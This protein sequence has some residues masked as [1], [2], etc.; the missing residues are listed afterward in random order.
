MDVETN[1]SIGSGPVVD[2]NCTLL[3][4]ARWRHRNFWA[5]SGL[6]PG[7]NRFAAPLLGRSTRKQGPWAAILLA[8]LVRVV[9]VVGTDKHGRPHSQV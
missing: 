3:H 5:N 7:S 6:N 2:L 8:V 4:A 9:P 1:F